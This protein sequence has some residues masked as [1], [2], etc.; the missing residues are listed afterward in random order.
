MG[1]LIPHTFSSPTSLTSG[2][3]APPTTLTMLLL[4]IKRLASIS[5]A[6]HQRRR[7]T[8]WNPRRLMCAEPLLSPGLAGVPTDRSGGI[9]F[10]INDC[11]VTG[12]G[13]WRNLSVHVSVWP[14]HQ[15]SALWS[16]GTVVAPSKRDRNY[17]YVNEDFCTNKW[18]KM[19]FYNKLK[20]DLDFFPFL[21]QTF[22]E[23][24]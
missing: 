11:A 17:F 13:H 1:A 2:V 14:G 23:N 21:M 24:V 8:P 5:G 18:I 10:E 19:Q 4:S 15:G 12:R 3:T 9:H 6:E 16:S 20:T 22:I 7:E